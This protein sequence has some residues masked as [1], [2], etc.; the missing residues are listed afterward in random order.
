MV[1]EHYFRSDF[2]PAKPEGRSQTRPVERESNVHSH[3]YAIQEQGP[4][5]L[6]SFI[7]NCISLNIKDDSHVHF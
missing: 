3:L 7:N 2:G 4:T 6:E 5:T 1:N